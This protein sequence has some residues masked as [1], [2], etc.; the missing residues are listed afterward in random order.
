ML[1]DKNFVYEWS[2]QCFKIGPY[3]YNIFFPKSFVQ[4]KQKCGWK[5]SYFF[6]EM[7]KRMQKRT[8]NGYC[9]NPL[10]WHVTDSFLKFKKLGQT[11]CNL[12]YYTI[13]IVSKNFEEISLSADEL[14]SFSIRFSI[15]FIISL[16]SRTKLSTVVRLLTGILSEKFWLLQTDK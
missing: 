12:Q 6:I 11:Q 9:A 8:K 3:P 16:I 2:E 5:S 14:I 7:Q 15:S 4:Y 10:N 1:I 13:S